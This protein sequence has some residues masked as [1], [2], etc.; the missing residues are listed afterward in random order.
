MA[1]YRRGRGIPSLRS[2]VARRKKQ[3]R[4]TDFRAQRPV[5]SPSTVT[6]KKIDGTDTR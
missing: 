2:I 4:Y 6:G 3:I 5:R 1:G